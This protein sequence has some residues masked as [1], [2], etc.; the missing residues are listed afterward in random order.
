M[1]DFQRIIDDVRNLLYMSSVDGDDYFHGAAADLSLAVDEVNERLRKCGGLLRK[2]LRCEALQL[3][4]IEPNL[5]DVVALLDFPEREQ[6]DQVLIRRGMTSP[7]PLLLDV[8]ADL[9]EAY[10]LAQPLDALLQR[11][12]LLAMSRAPLRLRIETLRKLA[13]ADTNNPIWHDDLRVFEAE[14]LTEIRAETSRAMAAGDLAALDALSAELENGDWREQRPDDLVMQIAG[15]RARYERCQAL[16]ALQKV[17]QQLNEAFAAFDVDAGRRLRAEWTGMTRSW[18]S[19]VSPELTER[20]A[21]ALQ[22]LQEQ[23]DLARRQERHAAAVGALSEALVLQ[24]PLSEVAQLHRAAALGGEIPADVEKRYKTY[25]ATLHTAVARRNRLA[26]IGVVVGLLLIA[27]LLGLLVHYKMRQNQVEKLAQSL[28]RLQAAGPEA[29][30]AQLYDEAQKLRDDYPARVVEDPKIQEILRRIEQRCAKEV[31][32]RQQFQAEV[33]SIRKLIADKDADKASEAV[34]G[35]TDLVKTDGDKRAVRDLKAE[36][37]KLRDAA[38]REFDQKLL[39]ELKAIEQ[40]VD[41]AE[42]EVKG[43]SRLA[44]ATL[45]GLDADLKALQGRSS[46]AGAEVPQAIESLKKRVGVIGDHARNA[47]DEQGFLDRITATVG[48]DAGP[49]QFLKELSAFRQRFPNTPRARSFERA[50]GEAAAWEWLAQWN[51]LV[52]ALRKETL[53]RLNPQSAAGYAATTKKLLGDLRAHPDAQRFQPLLEC[54]RA[55]AARVDSSGKPIEAK[56]TAILKNQVVSDVW[57]VEDKGGRRWY[58]PEDPKLDL[59]DAK[60]ASPSLRKGFQHLVNFDLTA[61]K[62]KSLALASEIAAVGRAPQVELAATLKKRLENGRPDG[63]Q[64]DWERGF[65]RIVQDIDADTHTDA[66]LR[67]YLLGE[68]L[69]LGAKGSAFLTK[70]FGPLV[71]KLNEANVTESTNWIDPDDTDARDVRRSAQKVLAAFHDEMTPAFRAIGKELNAF[72]VGVGTEYRWIGWLLQSD[73]GAWHCEH[74]PLRRESGELSGD[75]AVATAASSGP[76]VQRIGRLEQDVAK[77]DEGLDRSLLLQGR[78][79]YLAIP[80]PSARNQP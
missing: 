40:R 5:L 37:D 16:A 24:K 69:A 35:L 48:D 4:E 7:A 52:A 75:L 9:N 71:Q 25:V 13:E 55:V 15:A 73:D 38:R 53:A 49:A 57:Y 79:V 22:W 54:F 39:A 77:I 23:D 56:L 76:A 33:D 12:R 78:P 41:K 30:D 21:P 62:V 65:C 26:I 59:A 18:D 51:Q 27:G 50:A 46:G 61:R 2:G 19:L 58:L 29:D 31:K 44:A 63:P 14:R 1:L 10:A 45:A 74:R 8:A 70:G 34:A 36:I 28:E 6:W 47:S 43:N 20:V 64:Q 68:T 72:D 66:V 42:K 17:E 11:H 60:R 3:C 67:A 80:A 32:R